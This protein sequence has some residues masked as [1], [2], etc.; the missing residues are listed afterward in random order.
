M[1][2]FARRGRNLHLALVRATYK[3][4][5][6]RGCR[7]LRSNRSGHRYR[8]IRHDQAILRRRIREIAAARVRYGYFR[9]YIVLRR[10]GLK[11]NHK[12][13]YRLY[14]EEGVSMRMRGRAVACEC[15][16]PDG[17]AADQR[18]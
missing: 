14:R 11:I 13:D 6:R 10:E 9:I 4:S 5:E 2:Y 15:C 12:R 3:V 7:V 1:E 17:A 18:S 8:A 16:A